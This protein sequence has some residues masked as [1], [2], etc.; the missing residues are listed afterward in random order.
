MTTP[1]DDSLLNLTGA[2]MTAWLIAFAERVI[3]EVDTLTDLDRRAGDGDFGWNISSALERVTPRLAE[4]A[5]R[6]PGQILEIVSESFLGA[7]GTSGA[8]FGL[9]FGRLAKGHD[10]AWDATELARVVVD[11]TAAVQRL[12]GAQVGHKTMVD[13]MV[14]ATAAL[15]ESRDL[16]WRAAVAAAAAAAAEGA[17][18]TEQIVAV[19]GRASYV[20]ERARGVVDPGALA[21]AWFFAAADGVTA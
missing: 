5:D 19:R 20:G 1:T 9:W 8:L 16:P 4:D 21:V 6:S 15:D 7:G 10:G 2:D 17:A 12:G 14:P 11:A 3:R 18:S 13:A